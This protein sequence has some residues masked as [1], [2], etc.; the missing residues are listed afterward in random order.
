MDIDDVVVM[1]KK[2]KPSGLF[3]T[4]EQDENKNNNSNINQP[5]QQTF[6]LL[7]HYNR[8]I[9]PQSQNPASTSRSRQFSNILRLF[10]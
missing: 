3:S 2:T 10:P 7:L 4:K 6:N 1:I 8:R 5:H 9:V